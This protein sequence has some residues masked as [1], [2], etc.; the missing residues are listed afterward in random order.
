[1]KD[2]DLLIDVRIDHRWRLQ[3]VPK[4]FVVQFQLTRR[5]FLSG[6][7][8]PIID[9]VASIH[10]ITPFRLEQTRKASVKRMV[11]EGMGK[12]EARPPFE[13]HQPPSLTEGDDSRTTLSI[14]ISLLAEGQCPT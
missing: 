4:R 8:V 6:R 13:S 5:G 7:S 14:N 12:S 10:V 1:M 11:W 3:P 9:E 2:F